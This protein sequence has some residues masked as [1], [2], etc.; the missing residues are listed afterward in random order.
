MFAS[1][2]VRDST[3]RPAHLAPDTVLTGKVVAGYDDWV[4]IEVDGDKKSYEVRRKNLILPRVTRRA[5]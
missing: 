3:Y 4:L 2:R 5:V 1:F